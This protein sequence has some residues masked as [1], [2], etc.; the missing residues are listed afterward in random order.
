MIVIL[1]I[2]NGIET[3]TR[4]AEI[5]LPWVMFF[6]LIMV[7]L[8]PP[9]F[10]P[11][12]V[13]PVLGYGIQPVLRA[14]IPLISTPYMELVVFL[15][16]I[17]YISHSQ[18]I[19]KAFLVGTLIGGVLLIII[20]LLSILVLGADLTARHMY[21]SY[22]LAK[23]ISIGAFL[24]RLEVFMAGIWFITIYF[25]LAISFYASVMTTAELFK[26]SDARQLYLP[27]GM[28]MIVLSVIAYPNIPYFIQFATKIYF[29]YS[30]PCAVVFPMLIWITAV[31]RKKRI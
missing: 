7:V 27:L 30:L 15:L 10:Q 12:Y 20:S 22:S 31:I 17:P 28:I 8:L 19:G 5:F 2:R 9:Q 24:Q 6:F 16:I 23:K 4:T 29:P 21:P 11:D 3:F 25:K 14:V 18:K 1:G 26:L 13:V